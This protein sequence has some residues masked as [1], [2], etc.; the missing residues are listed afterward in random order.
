MIRECRELEPVLASYVDGES[1]PPERASIDAH[2]DRCA[3]CRARVAGERAAREILRARR[4][5]LRPAASEMLRA[6][7]SAH[8][9][10][11]SGPSATPS[12][13]APRLRRLVPLSLAA[14][15]LLAVAGVFLFGVNH[16]AVAAQLALDHMK[17]FDVIGDNGP[18]DSKA[19]A[20]AWRSA[21]GWSIGVPPSSNEHDLQLVGVRR[22]Y[23]TDGAAAHCMYRWRG[24]NLSVYIV[25]HPVDGVGTAQQVV[26]KFGHGAVMWSSGPRTYFVVTRGRPQGFEEVAGYVRRSVR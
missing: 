19:A 7:C 2:L 6:R 10:S 3:S 17:C 1:A 25:P 24:Q 22:C 15:L 20:E 8:R 23:S 16:E 13:F 4:T 5:E 12:R 26:E 18:T 21:R 14:T 9:R 11:A